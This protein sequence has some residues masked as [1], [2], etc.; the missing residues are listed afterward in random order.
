MFNN[1]KYEL[2][3]EEDMDV[4]E[5]K[6]FISTTC[7]VPFYDIICDIKKKSRILSNVNNNKCLDKD[8]ICHLYVVP[9]HIPFSMNTGANIIKPI[10]STDY[11]KAVTILND[12]KIKKESE[13]VTDLTNYTGEYLNNLP[14]GY[15]VRSFILFEMYNVDYEGEW[16]Y[17]KYHGFG[18]RTVKSNS[19]ID[20]Y[21]GEWYMG[22]R[23]GNGKWETQGNI[24][25]GTFD[26]GAFVNGKIEYFNGDVYEGQA[27][28]N[29]KH[30]Y[31]ILTNHDGTI[32]SSEW[33]FDVQKDTCDA[34]ED[35]QK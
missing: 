32:V 20:I 19:T 6:N 9:Q 31:G 24:Y 30:G 29:Y 3:Y 21:I 4:H 10:I 12:S 26:N 34:F 1:K 18:K 8:D 5:V 23:Q 7:N 2:P 28:N 27:R 25:T 16:N 22:K 13:D 17:G 33:Y 35:L 11:L 15:G 14:H